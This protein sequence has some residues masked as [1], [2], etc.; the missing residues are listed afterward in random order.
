MMNLGPLHHLKQ[1]ACGQNHTLMVS[2]HG[3]IYS[4][5]CNRFGQMGTGDAQLKSSSRPIIVSTLSN[6]MSSPAK[7]ACT[8]NASFALFTSK[9]ENSLFSWGSSEN[10]QLGQGA[11]SYRNAVG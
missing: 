8:S 10:G 2:E 5:G 6:A 11:I 1:V 4:M 9:N 7:I 3:L